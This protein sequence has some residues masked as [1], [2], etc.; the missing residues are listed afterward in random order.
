MSG[1]STPAGWYPDPQNPAQQR[2][3][4][5][6]AWSEATQPVA[7]GAP[8]APGYGQAVGYGYAQGGTG[9]QAGVGTRFLA[10]L[11][12]GII[13]GIPINLV[14]L[15]ADAPSGLVNLV[16]LAAQFAYFGFMES[17]PEGQTLGKKV[18]KIQVVDATTLQPGIEGRAW[19]RS[20]GRILSGL[21]CGLGYLWI[22]WDKDKMTW[23]DK[24]ATTRVLKVQ[25]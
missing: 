19:T 21:V 18:M 6:A 14:L 20:G 25:G 3:W 8:P 22:L 10:A 11:I 7:G 15:A 9:E 23:H 24:M 5:G 12:D 4:D 13:I 2:Y 17:K 16:I 1:Q